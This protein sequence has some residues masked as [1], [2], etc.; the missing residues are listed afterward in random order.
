MNP[1]SPN[2][3]NVQ[4]GINLFVLVKS[5]L[6]LRGQP[7]PDQVLSVFWENGNIA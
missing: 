3:F 5:M 1:K 7:F 4:G 2:V 6:L